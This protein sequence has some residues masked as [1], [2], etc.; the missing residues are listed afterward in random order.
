MGRES[1]RVYE[2]LCDAEVKRIYFKMIVTV[3]IVAECTK[4][5]SKFLLFHHMEDYAYNLK[6]KMSQLVT[7]MNSR[8]HFKKAL[9]PKE[10]EISYYFVDFLQ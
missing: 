4:F 1:A 7:I 3:V 5:S 10:V 9:I 6:H 2:K 8:R